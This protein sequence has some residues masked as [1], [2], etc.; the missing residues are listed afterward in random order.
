MSVAKI[1]GYDSTN[2]AFTVVKADEDNLS[3]A[4]VVIVPETIPVNTIG[5]GFIGG[6]HAV[7][8]A[9]GES[10]QI[11]D[12]V[13]TKADDFGVAVSDSGCF[14]IVATITVG[15]YYYPLVRALGGGSTSAIDGKVIEAPQYADPAS[16]SLSGG[17]AYYTFRLV[18]TPETLYVA[19]TTYADNTLVCYPTV[20]DPMYK[21]KHPTGNTDPNVGHQPD[22]S[23]DWWEKQDEIRVENA[24]GNDGKDL[25]LF[26]PWFEV[27]KIVPITSRV[28]DE[29]TVYYI[30]FCLTY[31][32]DHSEASI[33]WNETQNRAMA[34]FK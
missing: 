8:F 21:A 10:G 28:I 29:E 6:I 13:G 12:K 16:F 25:R 33:R 7:G 3:I 1:T 22:T 5:N 4:K 14:E 15:A 24:L 20:N 27:G 31:G 30:D 11:G 9:S 26:V 17:R 2:H 18:G 23:T 19:G 32:G 34:C